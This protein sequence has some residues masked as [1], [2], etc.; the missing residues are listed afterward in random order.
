[1]DSLCTGSRQG[2]AVKWMAAATG[3][4]S[5]AWF[6][7]RVIPKP[8]RAAYPCQRAVAPLASGF[9]V[10]FAGFIAA[11]ALH[12]QAM[13]W[14]RH[15]RWAL[16]AALVSLAGLALWLPLGVPG[17][18][19]AVDV[20]SPPDPPNSPIG[21]G[22]GIKP[23]RVV[24]A[25][26]AAAARWD[27]ANGE[28][29]DDSSTDQAAVDRMMSQGLQSLTGRK[30][31]KQAW[32]ALFQYF[33]QSRGL[34]KA[35][36]R[37]GE[38]VAIKLNKNQD[39]LDAWRSGQGMPSPHVVYALVRQ[40]VEVAGVSGRDIILYD[41]SRYI[42]DPIYN[43]IRANSDPNFQAVRFIV[44][45]KAAGKGRAEASPDRT[46]P[47]HFSHQSLPAAYL[48]AQLT[49]AKYLVNVALLRAHTLF[50]VTLTAKN[51]FGSTFFP[52]NGGWTPAPLHATGSKNNPM[53]SYNC[54]VDLT[55]H[56]HLGGKTLL[57]MVDGL[58]ASEHQQGKVIRFESFG[59]T[60]TASL[61]FSQDPVA[62]DSVGL[63][64]LRNEPRATQVRGTPDNY[65]HEAALAG[66]PPSGTVYDPEGDGK[67]LESL[68]VHEHWNS[69]TDRQYSRN[70]GKE[71]GIELITLPSSAP[72]EART[73]FLRP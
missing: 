16:V 56:K 24:W 67:P 31:D 1:M 47:V 44:S 71:E 73:R 51:H 36:Y 26:E 32:Q 48:P 35:G 7:V 5:L 62:I 53:G 21:A 60:W 4:L 54:L 29:W 3:L 6:V 2:A 20:F 69:A 66:K 22:K 52:D 39:R 33:H 13:A 45:P 27:G 15:S 23:G 38:K 70:L 63:D 34:G 57:Y 11:K 30:S 68:G 25:H 41:A 14:R 64:I 55:G 49:E 72:Q 43:K 37:A 28:W 40:L 17:E 61:F 65:L 12:R 46:S 18:V 8:S 10:W 42:G 9:V 59:D 58:Y 50:G 19:A